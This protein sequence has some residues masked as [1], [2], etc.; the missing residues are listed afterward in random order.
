MSFPEAALK[1]LFKFCISW[2][3]E[4]FTDKLPCTNFLPV[5]IAEVLR[6]GTAC[7]V[8]CPIVWFSLVE[9]IDEREV[10]VA[11]WLCFIPSLQQPGQSHENK[12]TEKIINCQPQVL[13]VRSG[14]NFLA[15]SDR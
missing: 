14:K 9:T 10:V 13:M 12:G 3:Q 11:L 4:T 5:R 1:I 15:K 2:I 8:R 6:L 7:V